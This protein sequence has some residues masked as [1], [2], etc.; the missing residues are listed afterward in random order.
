M[1]AAEAREHEERW[2]RRWPWVLPLA[3]GI[4]LGAAAFDML[5]EGLDRLGAAA[6][7]WALAGLALFV[8]VRDGL[9]YLGRHGAGWVATL[10]LWLHSLLEG[11]VAALGFGAGLL[12]GL[13]VTAGLILH[14]LP[15]AGGA[16]ALMTATGVSERQSLRRLGVTYAL[17]IGGFVVVLFFLPGLSE[18]AVTAALALGAGGF[19][20]LAYL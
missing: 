17:L 14:L 1:G 10:G 9:D 2:A 20:Y 3:A 8:L 16:I 12:A 5:P 18:D 7:L 4:F 15:E 19:V 13:L 6:W 11:V